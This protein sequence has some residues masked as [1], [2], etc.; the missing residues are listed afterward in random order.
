MQVLCV[1]IKR[2]R[3]DHQSPTLSTNQRLWQRH[4]TR[5]DCFSCGDK[6]SFRIRA[7]LEEVTNFPQGQRAKTN[8]PGRGPKTKH[9]YSPNSKKSRWMDKMPFM[10]LRHLHILPT[11][12]TVG[13]STSAFLR[14]V[15]SR[16]VTVGLF[17][18]DI[19]GLENWT[20]ISMIVEW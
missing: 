12:L 6:K 1:S 14:S 17:W 13:P 5:F 10:S 11:A 8:D 15:V 19:P 2:N 4:T 7:G 16:P 3:F 18:V 9:T 20:W